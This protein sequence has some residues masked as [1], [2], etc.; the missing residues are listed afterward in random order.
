MMRAL[1]RGDVQLEVESQLKEAL[2]AITTEMAVDGR[3]W[4]D[5]AVVHLCAPLGTA[6]WFASG[7]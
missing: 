7:E 4:G 2:E 5:A 6:L 3:G 1:E